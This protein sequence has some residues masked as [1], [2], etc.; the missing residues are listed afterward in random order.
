M[1]PETKR[2]ALAVAGRSVQV[3]PTTHTCSVHI[4]AM[5]RP[6]RGERLTARARP[7][8]RAAAKANIFKYQLAA[9]PSRIEENDLKRAL[10]ESLE[11]VGSSPGRNNVIK[12]PNSKRARLNGNVDHRTT[13]TSTSS[14]P[15]VTIIGTIPATP[16]KRTRFS[17]GSTTSN[18]HQHNNDNNNKTKCDVN[19]NSMIA[20][21]LPP[22]L[23][24]ISSPTTSRA[25]RT[26]SRHSHQSNGIDSQQ[27]T[28]T[29]SK[30]NNKSQPPQNCL[31][32]PFS[33]TTTLCKPKSTTI[34]PS[35]PSTSADH[36][37]KTKSPSN[38]TSVSR[39]T[40]TPT[41]N[42]AVNN[43]S[44]K[45]SPSSVA[46]APNKNSVTK[47]SH[48]KDNGITTS[49]TTTISTTTTSTNTNGLESLAVPD[50]YLKSKRE[51]KNYAYAKMTALKVSTEKF[52]STHP[53][54][55]S[56]KKTSPKGILNNSSANK[57]SLKVTQQKARD[58][59]N[60]N[61]TDASLNVSN[62][63]KH[64]NETK[65]SR[66]EEDKS[67]HK[68]DT[69]K[70]ASV[71]PRNLASQDTV[72]HDNSKQSK[73]A[74]SAQTNKTPSKVVNLDESG[75]EY[76]CSPVGT[77]PDLSNEIDQSQASVNVIQKR[78]SEGSWSLL[79][80]PE[81]KIIYIRDDEPPR[82]LICYPAI[83]HV[84]GDVIQVRDSVLLRS[85]AGKKDLPY[86]AKVCSFWEDAETGGVMMSL[87]WYYRPEHTEEGRKPH[88]L[89]DEIF[90]SRH[91]D[92][93]SVE[94]IDDKCYVLTFNE[95]CRYRKR[96]K[97]EQVSTTWSLTDVT[98]PM[99]NESYPRRNRIPDSDVNPELVFCCRQVY[100]SRM[101]RLL[102][103]P[104][105]NPKYGHI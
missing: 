83:K 7:K 69:K 33:S 11:D 96:C 59:S 98:I 84:E 42:P 85:G 48:T 56:S 27:Q 79:G 41:F 94:C 90:A 31:K 9:D 99:S 40:Q 35:I 80:V 13:G 16:G 60:G 5:S 71:S 15:E 51:S 93:D 26:Y 52:P 36:E 23:S 64:G 58:N 21:D 95:Y 66:K 20:L 102:K 25:I 38:Q 55:S 50:L 49:S 28:T 1:P 6:P 19:P 32:A 18:G 77:N 65:K 78:N 17:A 91:R 86:I 3:S 43:D 68:H 70:C 72:V 97:M 81:E 34:S 92:V 103:N 67:S 39:S 44:N 24:Q 73:G 30:K 2:L 88:H 105:I 53:R 104:L 37:T 61:Q 14:S 57:D 29:N 89:V 45:S 82:R 76:D 100:D 101:K 8:R 4:K 63:S 22:S 62:S 74:K 54:N 12:P 47:N 10:Q 87:F 46:N 75:I